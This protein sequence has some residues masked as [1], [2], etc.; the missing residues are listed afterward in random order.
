[1]SDKAK[2]T[3][4]TVI[5][6]LVIAILVLFGALMNQLFGPEGVKIL[7]FTLGGIAVTW[8]I[9]YMIFSWRGVR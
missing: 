8:V 5:T 6:T 2:A 7:A 1:M 9:S 4:A 3:I